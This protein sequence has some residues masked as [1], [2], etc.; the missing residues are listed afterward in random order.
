MHYYFQ[1][2][3]ASSILNLFQSSFY[4]QQSIEIT[5]PTVSIDQL[6]IKSWV[7]FLFSNW[8]LIGKNLSY[9]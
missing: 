1:F 7:D 3:Q 5:L 9:F 8:C 6:V 4:H 2:T